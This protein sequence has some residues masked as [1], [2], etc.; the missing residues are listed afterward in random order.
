MKSVLLSGY[1]GFGNLGD[2]LILKNIAQ[3]FKELGFSSIYAVSGDLEYSRSKHES[4]QFSDRDNYQGI[5]DLIKQVDLV[6]LGG[7]GLFQDYNRLETAYLFENPKMGVHS[8]I[9]IPLIAHIYGKPI[10]YLFQGVGPLFTEDSR[11]F[12]KYAFSLSHYISVRDKESF[13]LLEE[14]GIR[15]VVLSS[16][17]TFLYPL[18]KRKTK[19]KKP[20]VGISLRQWVDKSFEDKI[21]TSI[22][23]FLNIVPED[24][25]FCFI[26]FQ[27]HGEA[28]TDS[29]IYER[30]RPH[31]K[32]PENFTLIKSKDY[33]LEEIEGIIA[34]LDFL[35]GMRL[36]SI[37][38]A[39]KYGI[40]F[41]AIPYCNKVDN[42]L[43]ETGLSDLSVNIKEISGEKIRD[44]FLS[45][46]LKPSDIEKRIHNGSVIMN[47][48]AHPG[49]ETIK[50]FLSN[51]SWEGL[52]HLPKEK[53]DEKAPLP[54][55][56]LNYK[57]YQEKL[58]RKFYRNRYSK[59]MIDRILNRRNYKKIIF[60]PSPI[61][62]DVPLFQRPHQ[63]FKELSKR[64]YL[65]FFLSPDPTADQ[66]EPIRE[67]NENL[68]LIKDI[69]VLYSL[70]DKPIVL[71]ITW[72]PN[73]VCKELFPNSIVIYDW[74]DE[75]E[76]SGYYSKFMEIDHRKL[77]LG[78]DIVLAT[79]DSLLE[80]ARILRP[81]TLLVPNGVCIEDFRVKEDVIPEDMADILSEGKPV[82][83]FYG[84]L[85]E[86]RMDYELI[87]YLCRE[88][89]DLNF[90]FIGP[91]YDGSD[92]KL[93]HAENLFLLGPK[94]YEDL[95]YYLRHF[96]VAIIPYKVDRITN[97][98][99]PVKLC[100]Y[101]A[102]GKPIVTTN[103]NE[104]R[105]FKSVLVSE[106]GEDFIRNIR[107]ALILKNNP[108][109]L[110]TLIEE[111]NANRWEDRVDQIIS[112]LES[113]RLPKPETKEQIEEHLLIASEE[114]EAV[115][116]LLDRTIYDIEVLNSKLRKTLVE[117]D[118]LSNQ[119]NQTM[120]ER[121]LLSNQ[122]NQTMAERD[123]LSN[124]LNQTM[125]ER[126]LLSNQLNQ[127]QWV[128]NGIYSSDFWKV[129]SLYYRIRDRSIILRS[130]YK[131]LKR[132]KKLIRNTLHIKNITKFTAYIQRYGFRIAI[133]KGFQNVKNKYKPSPIPN[134]YKK[135]GID[136]ILQGEKNAE[137]IIIY[138]PTIDWN[139]TL[140]QRPHQILLQLAR[141]GFIV[142]F[143]TPNQIDSLNSDFISLEKNL[144]L[145]KTLDAL[146]ELSGR[147]N[148]IL[149]ITNTMHYP[150]IEKLKPAKVIYD[151]IDELEVFSNYNSEMV[152]THEK[153]L[154]T[155]DIVLVTSERLWEKAQ[156]FRK[157]AVLCPNAVD[158]WHFYKAQLPGPLPVDLKQ[159]ELTSRP[160]IGYHGA[161]AEWVDYD[162]L[163]KVAKQRPNYDFLLIGI[164]Y[165]GSLYKSGVI[166]IS[167]IHYI[168]PKQYVELPNYVRFFDVAMIPFKLNKITHSTSPIKLFEYM[169]SLK[170]IVATAMDEIKKYSC[171]LMAYDSYEFANMLD[172]A[173]ALKN[174]MRYLENL[175]QEALK[176]TWNRRVDTIKRWLKQPHFQ[177]A[178]I[179]YLKMKLQANHPMFDIYLEYASST[180]ERGE[181]V[182][183]ILIN[184][185]N[186]KDKRYLD[187]GCAYGGFPIAFARAGVKEA[188]GIEIDRNL[189]NLAH[190]LLKDYSC[191]V[192]P[193][194]IVDD[195]LK[196][197]EEN[198]MKKFDIITCNDVIEHV[199]SPGLLVK[200]LSTLLNVDGILFM[201]I[202]N[203][204]HYK[205]VIHDGHYGLFGITLL[206]PTNARSYYEY[207]F[208]DNS[209]S[210]GEYLDFDSYIKL[211]RSHGL[212]PIL[213]NEISESREELDQIARSIYSLSSTYRDTIND[214][215]EHIREPIQKAINRYIDKFSSSYDKFLKRGDK[216]TAKQL[217]CYYGIEFWRFLLKK[218]G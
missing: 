128:L 186:I 42:L 106:N 104:C 200:K 159:R 177:R 204:F 188:I 212:E 18:K 122:L 49:I 191:P 213:L 130:V 51:I 175:R 187:V 153:L 140:F 193:I 203:A 218:R 181:S 89:R 30:I 86:W 90:V 88:C 38:L 141:K 103:M 96:D 53:P 7:G 145:C 127:T 95:K 68:Y 210:V 117:R 180:I 97:S 197:E 5:V 215:P 208:N 9:N 137:G 93:K 168:G 52:Y 46:V 15:D 196:W 13:R 123:L 24:Y 85:R 163:A 121:D 112:A 157:D 64:G 207:I 125:A 94:K 190:E 118:N 40:P 119:L 143:C 43:A 39:I 59:F 101:M 148:L 194:F 17:P 179:E 126:D 63:I 31:L 58:R 136:E 92:K 77:V 116:K 99:F 110:K 132:L 147:K 158:F 22:T 172:K 164:D 167:N 113:E 66:A 198:A 16:D 50:D 183:K 72:T 114:M 169:A 45:I 142:I 35:I 129:A 54:A 84:L 108:D 55:D 151:Y 217:H 138:P 214:L 83:G 155:A 176:N 152:I 4:I 154:K 8:Y 36:H 26:S 189:V 202:P 78:A 105:K 21:L 201:E 133:R 25:D 62:W 19:R 44:Q 56:W 69:D 75:L 41:L 82:V 27:D 3:L 74:I 173:I 1:Y 60:Y 161:L 107:K 109:Y 91:C 131:G 124:Q 81:D 170:P 33:S 171:V 178:L 146:F 156:T 184:Y 70:K 87:N 57:T 12:T 23:E 10:A 199:S 6:A 162:L 73:I 139:H 61:Q 115:Q 2:E 195:I 65:V 48:R 34:N 111:A 100:E 76:I 182:V 150:L 98:V 149:Y 216:L 80:E 192:Q 37:I 166:K 102:G 144:F 29:S 11:N 47:Q 120:A 134:T 79:S 160:I 211:F 165:D 71:W 206:D 14:L 135:V 32:R 209:Y 67:I 185:T 205:M 28:N 20:R 174:D